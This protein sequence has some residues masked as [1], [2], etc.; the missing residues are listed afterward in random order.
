MSRL[1]FMKGSVRQ[2]IL[3][4]LV[5]ACVAF[6]I[7]AGVPEANLPPTKQVL[8][9]CTGNHYRSR[10]A[11]ALFNQKV[12]DADLPWRAISRGLN[13]MPS[14]F[15]ISS[16][17]RR[18]LI[19]RGVSPDL[20]KGEPKALAEEDLEN[21]DLIVLMNESEHRPMM[22]KQFPMRDD[23]KI[24]YWHIGDTGEMNPLKACQEMTRDV[25]EVV[26]TLKH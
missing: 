5:C 25:E 9:V 23:R 16:L 11:A 7:N 8:F 19:K 12:H 22:E 24:R 26:R 4:G 20:C 15:G 2:F 1:D 13:L 18:E 21:S 3:H 10:F 6:S 17:A 14:Q